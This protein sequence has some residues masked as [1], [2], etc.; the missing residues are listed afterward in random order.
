MKQKPWRSEESFD[1]KCPR[2]RFDYFEISAENR[3]SKLRI[4]IFRV[5]N[6]PI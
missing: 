4:V 1:T 3:T 5:T 2:F 6:T